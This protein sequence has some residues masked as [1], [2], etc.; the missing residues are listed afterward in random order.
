MSLTSGV[1]Q[2]S[3]PLRSKTTTNLPTCVQS[4]ASDMKN[5]SN[6]EKQ[7]CGRLLLLLGIAPHSPDSCTTSAAR[8]PPKLEPVAMVATLPTLRKGM[9]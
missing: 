4:T 1:S 3:V 5:D 8:V 9:L 2:L 6:H 7:A